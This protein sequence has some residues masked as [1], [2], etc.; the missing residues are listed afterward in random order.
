M[1]LPFLA[2]KKGRITTSSPNNITISIK[3]NT[4]SES[5]SENPNLSLRKCRLGPTTI[6]KRE[7]L[8]CLRRND[9]FIIFSGV[10]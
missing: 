1:A 9:E 7:K 10:C 2:M 4:L 8:Y 3:K 6:S 5:V